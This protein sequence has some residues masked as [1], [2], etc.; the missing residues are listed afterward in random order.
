ML[1]TGDLLSLKNDILISHNNK[2]T[3]VDVKDYPVF[4]VGYS[5]VDGDKFIDLI[6]VNKH[7]CNPKIRADFNSKFYIKFG[8]NDLELYN[9]FELIKK[10][11]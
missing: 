4:E 8:K 3:K 7:S 9:Y 11:D 6:P 2:M 10:N 1:R 5:S